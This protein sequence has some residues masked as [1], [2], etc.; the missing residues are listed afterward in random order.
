VPFVSREGKRSVVRGQP[1][2]LRGSTVAAEKFIL[3]EPP[4]TWLQTWV[5]IGVVGSA[6]REFVIYS[7]AGCEFELKQPAESVPGAELNM[8]AVIFFAVIESPTT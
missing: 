8:G 3:G 5:E 4:K 7:L 6:S 2:G 1:A